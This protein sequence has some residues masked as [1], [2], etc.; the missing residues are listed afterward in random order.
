ML[1]NIKFIGAMALAIA[2]AV[3]VCLGMLWASGIIK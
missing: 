2:T 3:T 1:E